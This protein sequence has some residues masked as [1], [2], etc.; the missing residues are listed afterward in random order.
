M[1]FLSLTLFVWRMGTESREVTLGIKNGSEHFGLAGCLHDDL[2]ALLCDS[3]HT[4]SKLSN[5]VSSSEDL[6]AV[7]L[8]VPLGKVAIP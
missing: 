1:T 8:A 4:V 6:A 2:V 7:A 5:G 3:R